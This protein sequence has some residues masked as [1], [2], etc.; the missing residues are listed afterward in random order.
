MSVLNPTPSA[1]DAETERLAYENF[2]RHGSAPTYRD[3]LVH[4]YEEWH[5]FNRRYFAGQLRVPHLAIGRTSP[6]RFS[7]CSL[8]TNYGGAIGITLREGIAFGT[9]TRVV[10]QPWP[11]EGLT[12]FLG[13]ILLGESVKQFVLEVDGVTEEAYGGYGPRYA[14]K[15]NEIGETLGR[16]ADGVT[17]GWASRSRRS[18]RGRC[19]RMATTWTPSGS[20]TSRWPGSV[21]QRRTPAT[22]CRQSTSISSTSW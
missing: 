5:E 1:I 13:D 8:T 12:R 14:A 21:R 4:L 7:E 19:A 17:E 18:G 3:I 10:R 15:A 6:R 2:A 22:Q 9:Q 16:P 11:S 20:P